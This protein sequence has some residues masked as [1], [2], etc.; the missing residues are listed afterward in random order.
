MGGA[1]SKGN[2]V[3]LKMKHPS[4]VPTRDSNSGGSDPW[5]NALPTRPRRRPPPIR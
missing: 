3:K 1:T 4:D 5:Y 2:E